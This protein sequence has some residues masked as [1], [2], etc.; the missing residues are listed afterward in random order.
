MQ[1]LKVSSGSVN[2][3]VGSGGSK[4]SG[5][6]RKSLMNNLAMKKLNSGNSAKDYDINR[7]GSFSKAVEGNQSDFTTMK[8]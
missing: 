7:I 4:L 1:S 2:K 8:Q 5:T 6:E 3:S